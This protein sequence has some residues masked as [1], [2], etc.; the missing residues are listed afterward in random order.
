MVMTPANLPASKSASCLQECCAASLLE[1][2]AK[3]KAEVSRKNALLIELE[4]VQK[5]AVAVAKALMEESAAHPDKTSR[6]LAN[7]P[8]LRALI[9]DRAYKE[10]KKDMSE[11]RAAPE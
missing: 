7:K 8:Q 6:P 1:E 9:F 2:V 3:L 10:A 4:A 5:A 11:P